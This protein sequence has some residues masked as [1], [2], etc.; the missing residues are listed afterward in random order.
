[1]F[2][3]FGKF[4]YCRRWAVLIVWLVA[5]AISLPF[6]FRVV[7]PL[8]VGGFADPTLESSK[9]S[10]ILQENLGYSTSTF[11]VMFQSDTMNATDPRYIAEVQATLAGLKNYPLPHRVV[12]PGQ[13]PRQISSDGR[14]AYAL[15][16]V[17]ADGETA[18]KSLPQFKEALPK[19]PTLKKFVGGGPAFY[20]DV[21]K[22]S[23]SDLYRAEL[24]AFPIAVVA[25][26]LVFGSAVA[27]GLPVIVGGVAVVVILAALFGLANLMELSIFTLNLATLLGLGLGLDYAL[28]MTSRFREERR[29]GRTI[30]EAVAITSATAGKAVLFSGL[31]VLI[32]LCALLIFRINLLFSVGVGGVLVVFVSVAAAITLLPAILGIV[33]SK[34]EA[35]TLPFA[36]KEQKADES[37][38]LWAWL[39]RK[40]MRRPLAFF[41][42]T[43]IFL[44]LLGYPFL[45]V[46]FNSPDASIL[47]TSVESRQVFDIFKQEFNESE[48][49]PILIAVQSP[50]GSN[51]LAPDHIYYLYDFANAIAKDERVQ[52]VD[53]IVTVEPRLTKL[54]YQAIYSRPDV[55]Q[56]PFLGN[57][58][59]TYAKGNTTLIS[60]VSKYPSNS[61]E[62]QALVNKIR[63]S[64]V[65]N[66]LTLAVTG[67]TAG[68]MDVVNSLYSAFPIAILIIVA[69]T[70][71]VLLIL[72]RSV[73][74]PLKAILMNALSLAAS[75]GMLVFVFQD[76]NFSS[77]LNFQALNFIEPTLPIIMFCTLFGLSMDYEVFLLTR[78]KEHY[79]H[80]GDNTAAVAVGMQKSGKIITSAALI[81]VLVSLSFVTADIVLVKAL[82]LGI[83]VAVGIDATIVRGLLVPATMRLLGNWN[84]YAPKW[85]LKILPETKL[86]TENFAPVIKPAIKEAELV[87]QK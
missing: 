1:M 66:N 34:I 52:R 64:T 37:H 87:E 32:G 77:I 9:A 46:K 56:D 16:F 11:V 82:G 17:E 59:A 29:R 71:F 3:K 86:E 54:Q 62:T 14:T 48:L 70:Y 63:N 28:F 84:W 47:P 5:V 4:L 10:L 69:S 20:A 81:V 57:F 31:T 45:H 27:A 44:L 83:A 58:L 24:V 18:A 68:I 75:Y 19:P 22:V 60:V 50:K 73:L 76:G 25:M 15:V 7:E 30:E 8:K 36:R 13:N 72:F 55:I 26:L 78:I 67:G 38:G 21:E 42:P 41:F 43:L 51:I 49:S 40:V 85:L 33:G 2:Y 65:G 23:Q 53:S 80:T 61:S 74:L 39:A 35:W 12:P 79:D 6:V